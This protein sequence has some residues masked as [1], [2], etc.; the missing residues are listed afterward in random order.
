ME[1]GR[2][3]YKSS[4]T[5]RQYK[6]T[7]HYT[8]AHSYLVYLVTCLLCGSRPQYVGQSR[9]TMKLRHYGHRSEIQRG[10]VG[11]GEHFHDHMVQNGLNIDE[12]IEYFDLTIIGSVDQG[13]LDAKK[14]LDNLETNFQNRLMTMKKHGGINVRDDTKRGGKK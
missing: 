4:K 14:H 8:C 12:V 6:I 13:R 3:N 9:Q 7:R 11:L 5:G 10:E 1:N 2:Q